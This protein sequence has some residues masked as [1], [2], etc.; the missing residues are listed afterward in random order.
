LLLPS[1]RSFKWKD[2]FYIQVHIRIMTPSIENINN[3]SKNNR[4]KQEIIPDFELG[5]E[6]FKQFAKLS[7][8]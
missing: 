7:G 5:L 6:V 8:L 2:F 1:E 3:N 4:Y